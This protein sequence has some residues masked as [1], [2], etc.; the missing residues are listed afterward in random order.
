MRTS[1]GTPTNSLSRLI[2][3]TV[4]DDCTRCLNTPI[5]TQRVASSSPQHSLWLL[6]HNNT[7]S[8]MSAQP[9]RFLDLSKE[10]RLLIYEALPHQTIRSVFIKTVNGEHI[11]SFSLTVS[12]VQTAILETC[13]MVEEEAKDIVKKNIDQLLD[14]PTL[15]TPM[16]A[17]HMP[18]PA[19]MTRVSRPILRHCYCS[20]EATGSLRLSRTI[21]SSCEKV[22]RIMQTGRLFLTIWR[23][24][25]GRTCLTTESKTAP[26]KKASP[27]Y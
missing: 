27:D 4:F 9:F 22:V 7:Q 8:T 24:T 5:A 17:I 15:D 21:T 18:T 1:H 10:I 14:T 2:L 26:W 6:R 13:R 19:I 20:L 25:C 16:S 23:R 12:S 11:S 3:H